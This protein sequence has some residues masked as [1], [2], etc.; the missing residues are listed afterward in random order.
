[1]T[2]STLEKDETKVVKISSKGGVG[3]PTSMT[4]VEDIL[5]NLQKRDKNAYSAFA[6]K[7]ALVFNLINDAIKT[8]MDMFPAEVAFSRGIISKEDYDLIVA[9]LSDKKNKNMDLNS[10]KN[11]VKLSPKLIEISD[12]Y[13]GMSPYRVENPGPNYKPVLH[14]VAA[15]AKE[16]ALNLN[17][18]PEFNAGMSA[19]LGL[20]NFIQVNSNIKLTGEGGKNCQFTSFVVKYPPV[21]KG[22]II[23]DSSGDYDAST[24]RGKL[25]FKFK[26]D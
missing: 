9:L 23:A 15:L 7:H 20:S 21:F 8:K 24:I 26:N 6:T 5:K 18:D 19:L 17:S 13:K 25:S 2:D 4:A 16:V 11:G 12:K 22:K 10:F 14:V 3:A 1:L